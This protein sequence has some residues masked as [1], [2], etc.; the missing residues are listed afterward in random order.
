[1]TS[2]TQ[3]PFKRTERRLAGKDQP[4]TDSVTS[5]RM[6]RVRQQGTTP[7]LQVRQ[8]L[9]GLGLRYTTHNRDLPGSP[10]L[11]NR[12]RRWAVF[13]HGCY[14][15]RH[16]GC[17]KATTPKTNAEFWVTKFEF[18]RARDMRAQRALRRLGFKV[19]VIWECEAADSAGLRRRL[20]PW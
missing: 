12:S 10:D 5:E 1:V 16:K 17:D 18:N 20:K 7:E 15:H 19:L 14:W 11:A 9:T 13:V 6:G 4:T 8:A 2:S 3:Q